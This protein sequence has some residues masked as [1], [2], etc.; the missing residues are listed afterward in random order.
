MTA[1]RSLPCQKKWLEDI[2]CS[3]TSPNNIIALYAAHNRLHAEQ[4]FCTSYLKHAR[5]LASSGIFWKCKFSTSA[6]TRTGVLLSVQATNRVRQTAARACG[7][8]GGS[9]ITSTLESF[10]ICPRLKRWKQQCIGSLLQSACE[11]T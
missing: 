11:N 6:E 3:S 7:R 2:I 10:C 9:H 8:G 5:G 1:S 4:T